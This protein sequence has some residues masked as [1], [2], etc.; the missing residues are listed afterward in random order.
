MA[1]G[2]IIPIDKSE[3]VEPFI[4]KMFCLNCKET[5]GCY[6]KHKLP[7]IEDGYH[8]DLVFCECSKCTGTF[9]LKFFNRNTFVNRNLDKLGNK[10]ELY[11]YLSNDTENYNNSKDPNYNSANL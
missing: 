10:D 11:S 6:S 8:F 3:D 2:Y 5:S 9:E 1:Y 4:N 7:I